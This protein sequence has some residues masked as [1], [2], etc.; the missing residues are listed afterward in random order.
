VM[1][2]KKSWKGG[3]RRRQR[4]RERSLLWPKYQ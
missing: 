1:T 3:Q 4:N 2:G